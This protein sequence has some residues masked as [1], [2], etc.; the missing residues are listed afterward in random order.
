MAGLL[1]DLIPIAL[2]IAL[3]PIRLISTILLLTSTRPMRNVLAFLGGTTSVYLVVGVVA[4]LFFGR[5][6]S[7]ILV[8]TPLFNTILFIVGAFLLIYAA[9]SL[10]KVPASDAVLSGWI[11]H[12]TAISAGRAYLFGVIL[13]CSI[14]NLSVFLGGVTLIY[15][16]GL[17]VGRRVTALLVLITL[18]LL[19]Q[20]T[21]VVLYAAN[22]KRARAQLTALMPWLYQHNHAITTGF[23]FVVGGIFMVA[24]LNELIPLLRTVL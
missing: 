14:Q 8:G 2:F 10:F 9:R 22:A 16:T 20:M 5:A 24:S 6:L 11:Q 18:A 4:A 17:S 7:D 23:S 1:G 13:A 15:E 12:L 3:G 19:G 21:L